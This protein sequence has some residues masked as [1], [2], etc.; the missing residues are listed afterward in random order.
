M[1]ENSSM[2]QKTWQVSCFGKRHIFRWHLNESREAPLMFSADPE[3]VSISLTS[4]V[5]SAAMSTVV[6]SSFWIS[7]LNCF[8]SF[9]LWL[10]I[11]S[12]LLSRRRISVSTASSS[13]PAK[14][15]NSTF[16]FHSPSLQ[17]GSFRRVIP[18]VHMWDPLPEVYCHS[19]PFL[20]H[21]Q[22]ALAGHIFQS[23]LFVVR[24]FL[25]R[26]ALL[27]YSIAAT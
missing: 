16:Q 2:E 17:A 27:I 20:F 13:G 14:R 12:T 10:F 22:V 5:E 23:H 3:D 26:V 19:Q 11:S 25:C 21:A 15:V 8:S 1:D 6:M 9:A 24:A 18:M 7:S 4:L